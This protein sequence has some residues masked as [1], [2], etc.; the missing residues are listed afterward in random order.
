MIEPTETEGKRELDLFIDALISI[1]DE[2]ERDPEL[3]RQAPHTTRTSRVDEAGAA[4]RPVVRWQPEISKEKA[5][6]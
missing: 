6:N 1:A 2:A 5:A 4:R 3:V